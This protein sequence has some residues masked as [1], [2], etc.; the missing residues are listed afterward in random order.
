[1]LHT[2]QHQNNLKIKRSD[3]IEK[4]PHIIMFNARSIGN[5]IDKLII[6]TTTH[7][8][9]LIFITESWLNSSIQNSILKIDDYKIIRNTENTK[10]EEVSV[11]WKNC[12]VYRLIFKS[13]RFVLKT[14]FIF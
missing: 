10:K 3:K 9:N 4:Y 6:L 8:P 11:Y 2:N 12:L 7:K 14:S 5:K 13:F 1:M